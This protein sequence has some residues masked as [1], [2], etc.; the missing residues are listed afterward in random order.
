MP[1]T[2]SCRRKVTNRFFLITV[3]GVTETIVTRIEGLDAACW[4]GTGAA[5]P[6]T[7]KRMVAARM[8][9]AA[10]EVT[11]AFMVNSLLFLNGWRGKIDSF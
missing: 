4:G 1:L 5:W 11:R 7:G 6:A 9:D 2:C 3:L 8:V 10:T